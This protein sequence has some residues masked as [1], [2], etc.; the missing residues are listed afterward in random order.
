M[1]ATSDRHAK[2]RTRAVGPAIDAR[3]QVLI[4]ARCLDL[5]SLIYFFD[6]SRDL[7]YQS[8][9]Y[10]LNDW[11]ALGQKRKSDVI[12]LTDGNDDSSLRESSIP[13]SPAR[14]KSRS[15]SNSRDSQL[16]TEE[17]ELPSFRKL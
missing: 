1:L 16:V 13:S 5:C 6:R 8:S 17:E 11:L 10:I 12:D 9:S 14:K 3:Y 4:L 2:W 7:P 15:S